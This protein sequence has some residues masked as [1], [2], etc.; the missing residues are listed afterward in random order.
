MNQQDSNQASGEKRRQLT[1]G[2]SNGEQGDSQ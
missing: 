1:N 2:N